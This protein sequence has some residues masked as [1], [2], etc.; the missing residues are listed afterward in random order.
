MK[1]TPATNPQATTQ[2][3]IFRLGEEGTYV[4]RMRQISDAIARRA[5]E[6][7]EARG[8]EHGHDREDWFRAESELLTPVP[9]KVLAID[10]G[11]TI[12]AEVPGFAHKDVEVHVW[13]RRLIIYAREREK[14]GRERGK[15]LPNG[16]T[17]DEIFRVLDLPHEIE[18]DKITATLENEVLEVTLQKVEP[19][20]KVAGNVKAA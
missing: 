17:S 10:G 2:P 19:H 6:L 13:P 1:S 8:Y 20:K 15:A 12:R 7:F 16:K 11:L 9:A 18:P 3:A 4:E 14:S 5:Y